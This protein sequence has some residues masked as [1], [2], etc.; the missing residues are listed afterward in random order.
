MHRSYT[1]AGTG[2]TSR[3]IVSAIVGDMCSS[4][5]ARTAAKT[6]P[7]PFSKSGDL[8]KWLD[9]KCGGPVLSKEPDLRTVPDR[10]RKGFL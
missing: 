9:S 4:E 1:G 5:I 2:R 8:Q 7:P 3:P 10:E 6:I